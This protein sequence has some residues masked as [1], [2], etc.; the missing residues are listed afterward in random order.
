MVSFADPKGS[1]QCGSG[2]GR[3]R[4]P[5]AQPAARR[6]AVERC[7]TAYAFILCQGGAWSW[8]AGKP[9][10][11]SAGNV[12]R[13]VTSVARGCGPGGQGARPVARPCPRRTLTSSRH[14]E[15]CRRQRCPAELSC[16]LADG[17]M[18]SATALRRPWVLRGPSPMPP[19]WLE[20]RERR[21]GLYACFQQLTN[22]F[23]VAIR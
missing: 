17:S 2:L 22:A 13:G 20:E 8:K 11:S 16:W 5:S 1:P 10:A 7:L 18:E 4:Q 6:V 9:P 23:I 3:L 12:G 21:A 15:S 14:G 19:D